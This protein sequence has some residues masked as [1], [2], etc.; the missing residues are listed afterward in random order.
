MMMPRAQKLAAM[1]IDLT[2][3]AQPLVVSP[4]ILMRQ[5]MG[6]RR[7]LAIRA[8]KMMVAMTLRAMGKLERSP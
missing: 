5:I 2:A 4:A 6:Q 7:N 1:K 3:S 8:R